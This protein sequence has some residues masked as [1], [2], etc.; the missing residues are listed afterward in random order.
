MYKKSRGSNMPSSNISPKDKTI[1]TGVKPTGAPHIG[2]VIGAITP[3][4]D[5][6][7]AHAKSFLFIAD[8]HAV[9]AV[10]DGLAARLVSMTAGL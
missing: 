5:L 6:A 1:L 3:A 7:H 10:V 2:N 9:N 4:L 8:I